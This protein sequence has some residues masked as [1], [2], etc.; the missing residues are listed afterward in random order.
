MCPRI[1]STFVLGVFTA[2]YSIRRS[3]CPHFTILISPHS[4]FLLSLAYQ[5]IIRGAPQAAA[6]DNARSLIE[7][8]K[9]LPL[10]TPPSAPLEKL[11]LCRQRSSAYLLWPSLHRLRRRVDIS[12]RWIATLRQANSW[13]DW[14]CPYSLSLIPPLACIAFDPKR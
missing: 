14:D 12:K 3:S 11:F 6:Y 4:N 10:A 2:L 7:G 8:D 1:N 9:R 5:L 13:V